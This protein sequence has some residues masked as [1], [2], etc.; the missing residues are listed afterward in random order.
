MSYKK[1]FFTCFIIGIFGVTVTLVTIL[2]VLRNLP[3]ISSLRDYSPA[4]VTQVF[5]QDRRVIGEF[6]KERRYVLDISEI[7]QLAVEAFISAEDDR[8]FEHKGIDFLGIL[9]ATIAN[10]RAGR[11]VQGGSTI[12]QQVAKS[13]LLTPERS[14]SRKF[15]EAIL[16]SQIENNL[17]K[18]EILF[19]YLNQIYLGHGAYGVEA[20]ARTYFKKS[21]KGLTIAEMALLAGLAQAPSKYSPMTNFVQA[22][23]RQ[24]YVLG[25]MLETRHIDQEEHELAVEENIRLYHYEEIN[26][27]VSPYYVEHVRRK[28]LE[29]YGQEQLYTAGLKIHTL[30]NYDLSLSANKVIV[31]NVLKLSNRQGYLGPF[32][33]IYME[34]NEEILEELKKIQ[35]EAFTKKFPFL[36]LPTEENE[37]ISQEGWAQ[38]TMNKAQELGLY[39]R[40]I[41]LLIKGED[42]HAVVIRIEEDKKAAIAMI[43]GIKTRLSINNMSWA[44]KIE[45]GT[46]S[47]GEKITE[48]SESINVGDVIDVKVLNIPKA[49]LE[50]QVSEPEEKP[51]E[52][53]EEEKEEQYVRVALTQKP[54]AQSALVSMEAK[55]GYVV[56]MVGGVDFKNSEYNR[57]IQSKRQ[58]GSAFKPFIYAAALDRGYNPVSIIIDSPM[59]FENQGKEE[60]KW[61]PENNSERFYGDTTLRMALIKSRNVPTVKLLKDIQIPYMLDYLKNLDIRKGLNK[62]LSLALGSNIISLMDLTRSYALFPRNGLKIEPVYILRIEDRNGEILFEHDEEDVRAQMAQRWLKDREDEKE[63]DLEKVDDVVAGES[64][65]PTTV[66]ADAPEEEKKI[67]GEDK[68]VVDLKA[69]EFEDPTRAMDSKT[70]FIVGDMLRHV[71]TSGTGWRASRLGKSVGGKTGTTNDFVDAWF[72]GFSPEIVTG[73]WTGFDAPRSLGKGETGSRAALPAWVNYMKSCLEVYPLDTYEVPQGI[74]FVRVNPKDGSFAGSKTV[75]SVKVAFAEGTEPTIKKKAKQ[76]QQVPDSSDFFSKDF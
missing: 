40:E 37:D 75:D 3:A 33:K 39:E 16:A 24:L 41:D 69:P 23:R 34:D 50:D 74:V 25:R 66:V 64:T 71:V 10:L 48:V 15:K 67:G 68:E 19:L 8:F 61:I 7:P 22:R 54:T 36:I 12:T 32:K 43:G 57:V 9:R 59:I 46:F 56:A 44:K 62:D 47:N 5:S 17:T 28:V 31:K 11:V 30:A 27:K 52:E 65:E 60:F 58:P 73:V 76:Q 18:R 72:V 14:F 1:I 55:T 13:L 2:I 53:P 6:Y 51:G 29:E 26:N 38:Y 4:L 20:A 45:P 49:L 21:A 35:I 70:A 42:Y 63:A